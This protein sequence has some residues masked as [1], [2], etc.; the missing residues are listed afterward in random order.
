MIVRPRTRDQ[1][2]LMR[3]S[4]QISAY[5][6]KKVLKSIKPGVNLLTLETIAEEEI[7][8]RG[9]K[10]SFKT[11]EDYKWTTCITVNSEVVHGIPRDYI[12]RDGD[13]VSVDLGTVYK[14]WHTDTAWSVIAGGQESKFLKVGEKA[15]WN[16]I[17]QAVSG[18][19]VGDIS[20][21][22]QTEV[23]GA[24]Y[25]VVNSLVGHG[26]GQELH[27]EPE[28]PGIGQKGVGLLLEGGMTLAIEAIYT[29]GK[30]EVEVAKDNWTIVSKDGS[31]G[32]LFEMSIVVKDK[33]AEVLTDWR[34]I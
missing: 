6:L 5:A 12:L 23:E 16:G 29:E 17:L 7:V 10:P 21:A 8:K 22:I 24:G 18:N 31:L 25:S 20:D 26:V 30:G 3:K 34:G 15:M 9:G 19:T 4:G 13:K 28:V 32:G 27:E 14:G 1:L 2:A 33:K 11:V